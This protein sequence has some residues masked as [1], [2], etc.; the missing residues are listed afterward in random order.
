MADASKP[1]VPG[2]A[3]DLTQGPITRT[4]LAFALPTLGSNVLQSLNGS[5][6]S[7][8]VGRFLGEG[9]LAATTNA[10]L[11]MF[12][13]FSLGF[14]FGMATTVLVGQSMGA[15][16]LVG[17]RRAMGTTLGLFIRRT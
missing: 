7:I 4:L 8:W 10:N 11:V 2:R 3:R 12:L 14:G 9:A 6:N 5:I 17:A 15:R 1:A 16:D 13:M